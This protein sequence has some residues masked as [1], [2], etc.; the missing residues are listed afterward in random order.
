MR[1]LLALTLVLFLAIF[2]FSAC[3]NGVDREE[4]DRITED[5]GQMREPLG[6][7]VDPHDESIGN[8]KS[9]TKNTKKSIPAPASFFGDRFSDGVAWIMA[10]NS[11]R[12]SNDSWLYDV[13]GMIPLLGS[14][15]ATSMGPGV[16]EWYCVDKTGNVILKLD[17][18]DRPAS[19]FSNG[20]AVVRRAD[21]ILELID[22]SGK[23]ISSPKSGEYDEIVCFVHE[24][25]MIVV[26]RNLNTFQLTETQI[27]TIDNKGDWQVPL[28]G[29]EKFATNAT[30]LDH[31]LSIGDGMLRINGVLFNAFTGELFEYEKDINLI[32]VGWTTTKRFEKGYGIFISREDDSIFATDTSGNTREIVADVYSDIGE[33]RDGLFFLS[34][35]GMHKQGFY[36]I[37]GNMIVDLSTYSIVYNYSLE[38]FFYDS[39][40]YLAFSD[41]YC[42][43][44]LSNDQGSR[45]F[46]VIDKTGN[47]MFEPKPFGF[48]SI[49]SY[50]LKSFSFSCGVILLR[51]ESCAMMVNI[52]G[53]TILESEN[54]QIYD[55]SEGAAFVNT[56]NGT[57]YIDT[58]GQKLF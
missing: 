5:N 30:S 28:K 56:N 58:A 29:N 7:P 25:G 16:E 55:F 15:V 19:V 57:Y 33:Y 3:S 35:T 44:L 43:L 54:L 14:G 1:K 22:K 50:R 2:L 4:Y 10:Q 42:L 41:G 31:Y 13:K 24:F 32:N 45:F 23:V 49:E 12:L 17:N 48:T 46:T 9:I 21:S 20:V 11:S 52:Y 26:R 27:G 39:P 34:K 18:G 47:F 38:K 8:N 51:G 40:A 6:E 37:D 36:D 53:E